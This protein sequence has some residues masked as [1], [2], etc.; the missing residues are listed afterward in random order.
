MP[1]VTC[2]APENAPAEGCVCI[3]CDEYETLRLMDY[4]HLSQEEC[5]VR[6]GVSRA[7]VAR[8]YEHARQAIAEALVLGKK[9][10]IEGGDVYVCCGPRPEC[11]GEAHCCHRCSHQTREEQTNERE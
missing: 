8:L 4:V 9:L 5:A 7:T 3:G 11:A 1:S 6:M 2:F 10:R